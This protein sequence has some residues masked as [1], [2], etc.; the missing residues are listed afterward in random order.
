MPYKKIAGIYKITNI[1]TNKVYIGSSVNLNSRKTTHFSTLRKG[2]HKNPKLQNSYNKYGENA[3]I[4]EV[5][6]YVNDNNS[7]LDREQFY[8][9]KY[10]SV[11]EGYNILEKAGNSLGYKHSPEVRELISK[12]QKGEGNYFWGKHLSNEHKA[13]ISVGN[14]GKKHSIDAIKKTQQAHFK[15]IL[16]IETQKTYNSILHASK[17]LGVSCTAISNVLRGKTKTCKGYHW[18]YIK[19]K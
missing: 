19:E 16:N 7:L 1:I 9:N 8:I 14:K 3:F 5:L 10:N 6:E 12:R 11:T 2:I 4:F 15:P 13:R 17:E 18:E